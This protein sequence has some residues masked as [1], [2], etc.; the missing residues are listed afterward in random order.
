MKGKK[1]NCHKNGHG[2]MMIL[3]ALLMVGI[4]LVILSSSQEVFGWAYLSS[5]IVP[6]IICLAMHGLMMKLMMPSEK[7]GPEEN[8]QSMKKIENNSQFKA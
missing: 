8:E 1:S 7:Q 4:P 6:L 2:W 5:A 3:C